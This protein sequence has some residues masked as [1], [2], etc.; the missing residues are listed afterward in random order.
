MEEARLRVDA[1]PKIHRDEVTVVAHS[2]YDSATD[3]R[4]LFKLRGLFSYF[5]TTSLTPDKIIN[6]SS[7]NTVYHSPYGNN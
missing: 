1:K 3:L 5:R 7:Y 6:C 4:V 2:F